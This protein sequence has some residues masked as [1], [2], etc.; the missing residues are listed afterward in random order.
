MLHTDRNAVICD[1]AETYGIYDMGLLPVKTVA[2][3][4]AGLRENSRIRLK[5]N[6]AK[7]SDE[8][9]LLAHA[10]DR[11]SVLIWQQT[12]DGKAGRNKPAFIVDQILNGGAS[13]NIK[14]KSFNTPAEFWEAR[15][16][17]LKG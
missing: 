4:C 6:G 9:M 14:G 17:I 3:L 7:A 2:I 15:K 12:K 13:R 8:I 11:L 1:L 16:R 5:I 10:V